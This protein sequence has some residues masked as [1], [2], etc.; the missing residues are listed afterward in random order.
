MGTG[1]NVVSDTEAAEVTF[2][3]ITADESWAVF[4]ASARR[5]L[6]MSGDEF[7]RELDNGAF[8]N[9]GDIDVMQVAM[10]RPSGR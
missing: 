8:R 5:V 6:N 2:E 9:C 3:E 10:L 1:G 7:V 4:D